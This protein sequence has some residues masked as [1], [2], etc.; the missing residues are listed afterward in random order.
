V[1]G[2]LVVTIYINRPAYCNRW[3]A[4]RPLDFAPGIDVN[5]QVDRALVSGAENIDAHM[6]RVFYPSDDTRSWDWPNQGGTGGGQY[7]DPWRLWFNDDDLVVLTSL[8]TGGQVIGLDQ[9]FPRPWSNPR[10]GLPYFTNIELDR[11]TSASFGGFAQTPQNSIAG[12]GTWGYGADADPAGTLAADVGSSD[13]TITVSDGSVAGPGDLI[14]LGYGRG[15]APLPSAQGNHAGDIAPYVGERILVT[16]VSA[17]PTGLT[18]SGAGV[19]LAEDNDQALTVTGTGALNAGEV[20]TLDQEDMLVEKII[21][22]VATVRRAFNGSTLADH[23]DA[24]IYAWRQ[25]SVL[26]A[27]LGTAYLGPYEQGAP[28]FRHRVPQL[29]R[30]LA[31]AETGNQLMQEG[32]GYARMVGSGENAHPAPGY[33]LADKWAEART[34]HGRKA[35]IRGI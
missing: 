7:A 35:R 29:I 4:M 15:S 30:D 33:S 9:V 16:D 19:T 5:S 22:P 24:V 6:H 31:I 2:E 1:G 13:A 27:Q 3:E 8:T 11:S 34:A 14:I 20:I 18:Q 12:A 10:K 32:S 26:R 17:V 28:V 23:S 25:W 21:G